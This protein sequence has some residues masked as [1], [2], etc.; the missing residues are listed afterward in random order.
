MKASTEY[1]DLEFKSS[2]DNNIPC[3]HKFLPFPLAQDLPLGITGMHNR[4]DRMF[5]V[6]KLHEIKIK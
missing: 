6:S 3:E 4:V 1:K 5:L 2:L